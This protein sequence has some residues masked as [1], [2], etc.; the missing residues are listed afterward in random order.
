[1]N[2]VQGRHVLQTPTRARAASCHVLMSH[3][4]MAVPASME[5][6]F[7]HVVVLKGLKGQIARRHMRNWVLVVHQKTAI[8]SLSFIATVTQNAQS[9]LAS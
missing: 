8:Q 2:C 4:K 1:M 9:R 5:K 7:T 3:A 6:I